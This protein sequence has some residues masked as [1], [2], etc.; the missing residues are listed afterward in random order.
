[1]ENY[2]KLIVG[3]YCIKILHR[4]YIETN[5]LFYSGNCAYGRCL[6]CREKHTSISFVSE[7]NIALH[8]KN[9]LLKSIT[10]LEGGI[11]EVEKSRNKVLYDVPIQ[12][13]IAVI[14]VYSYAKMSLIKFWKFINHYLENDSIN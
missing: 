11:Y 6:L 9:P 4:V 8:I 1:M 5:K 2:G 7:E 10:Q 13:G 3:N 12:I 14:A